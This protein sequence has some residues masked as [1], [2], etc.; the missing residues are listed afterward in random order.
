MANI[1][2]M[3]DEW[4]D[5]G[6][7]TTVFTGIGLNVTDTSSSASSLLMD[8]Q[9]G[10][11][12]KFLVD[13]DGSF[14]VSTVNI[15]PQASYLDIIYSDTVRAIAGVDDGAAMFKLVD[16]GF[17][18]WSPNATAS[19]TADLRLWRDAANTL[20]QRNGTNA[21]T[22]NLYNTYTDASN[23][24]R[25]ALYWS[26]NI[27]FIKPQK[28][29]TGSHRELRLGSSN[30]SGQIIFNTSGAID[31]SVNAQNIGLTND[32]VNLFK[33]ARL[34]YDE[35]VATL[36]ASP[37]VGMISRVTD[38]DSGLTFGNT[39]VNSG[40]GATDYL[41]WYNGTNWTVIGA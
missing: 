7:G 38:G 18:G 29:G 3:A 21:Q 22:F 32:S 23:Y 37:T 16:S 10:G 12:S 28:A 4:D 6:A 30:N 13:K 20:A 9:V 24:E 33:T 34:A 15:R 26:S 36:P 1:Y 27:F 39:V 31:L 17:F 35:T 11:E 14:G 40:S 5:E 8:L 25:G 2:A 41:V 19:S